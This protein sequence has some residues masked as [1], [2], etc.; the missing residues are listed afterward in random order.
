MGSIRDW[1]L[2][3]EKIFSCLNWL[4]DWRSERN[5]GVNA[6]HRKN[7]VSKGPAHTEHNLKTYQSNQIHNQLPIHVTM[8]PEKNNYSLEIGLCSN[9]LH[10]V[11]KPRSSLASSHRNGTHKI[12]IQ[13]YWDIAVYAFSLHDS[14]PIFPPCDQ[15]LPQNP[16]EEI[17]TGFPS[18]APDCGPMVLSFWRSS[19][20]GDGDGYDFFPCFLWVGA[21]TTQENLEHLGPFFDEW[22]GRKK[23][24]TTWS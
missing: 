9:Q 5:N 15:N 17:S 24:N 3:I 1:S 20:Q 16:S 7:K 14:F 8:P 13:N 6:A 4:A 2:K 11:G 21:G 12:D 22:K 23:Q 19:L 10:M 18:V